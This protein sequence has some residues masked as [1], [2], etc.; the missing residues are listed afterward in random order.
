MYQVKWNFLSHVQLFVTPWTIQSISSLG[1]NTGVGS[2]SLL[3][4]IF[5]TQGS[6]QG[7]LHC[8][9]I[10]Y[11]LSYQGSPLTYQ[12]PYLNL[13]SD[14]VWISFPNGLPLN[15]SSFCIYTFVPWVTLNI[16][17]FCMHAQSFQSCPT[18]G[19]YGLE[20]ARLLCPWDS[21]GKNAGVGCHALLQGIFLTQGLN[22]GPLHLRLCRRILYC[23]ATR[24]ALFIT[25]TNF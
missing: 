18:L 4:G 23:W 13:P 2:L 19:P 15:E 17:K 22:Q 24:K 20:L 8:R 14:T 21:P 1:Q 12:I 7:L 16:S 25:S 5:S 6:N 9:W 11:Q 10:L 3:Q